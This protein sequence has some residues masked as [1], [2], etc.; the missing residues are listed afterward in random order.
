MNVPHITQA[1]IFPVRTLTKLCTVK[2]KHKCTIQTE[3]KLKKISKC[4]E[5]SLKSNVDT[6]IGHTKAKMRSINDFTN[7]HVKS[8]KRS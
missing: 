1:T 6:F 2:K 8:N 5:K 3:I 4:T 7:I